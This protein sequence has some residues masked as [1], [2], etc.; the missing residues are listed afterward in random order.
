MT[1][2]SYRLRAT[3]R[4]IA[5]GLALEIEIDHRRRRLLDRAAGDVDHRP[6][7]VG[8]HAPGELHFARDLLGVDI[9]GVGGLVE[10]QQAVSANL[11]QPFRRRRQA[12]QTCETLTRV[13]EATS[14]GFVALDHDW[15]YIY[16]NEHA[17]RMFG[18]DPS[19][20]VGKH[21]WTEFPEAVDQPFRAAYER[22]AAEGKP[23]QIEAYELL[24]DTGGHRMREVEALD[25][26]K[27]AFSPDPSITIS[28]IDS[29]VETVEGAVRTMVIPLGMRR[30]TART[31]YQTWTT[32]E[33]TFV[34]DATRITM[35]EFAGI[36]AYN[37]DD[38]VIDRTGLTGLYQFKV[39]LDANQ[40]AIRGLRSDNRVPAL[41]QT[42]A[43]G[44]V[45]LL[46][47]ELK[48]GE[49]GRHAIELDA[50]HLRARNVLASGYASALR[51][52]G[53]GVEGSYLPN[54]AS[55]APGGLWGAA[56]GSLRLP[57]EETP[58]AGGLAP[59]DWALVT[60]FGAVPGD[61]LDDL[62]RLR[63][64]SPRMRVLAVA[65]EAAQEDAARSAGA[66][67]VLTEPF[68]IADIVDSIRRLAP[69]DTATVIDLVTGEVSTA[70]A[71]VEGPW[72]ATS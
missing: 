34:V 44:L 29:T 58:R 67:D 42:D 4:G 11:D 22:A 16:V 10:R 43:S 19:S 9:A 31:R 32:A 39:E 69:P 70:P 46:D 7:I 8:E 53:V 61:G 45:V 54:Y 63:V 14:D 27:T 35:S 65:T 37:I 72:F 36:L 6:A 3:R 41:V 57:V 66:D 51:L 25:E 47:S 38:P 2:R 17:G 26:L 13:L 55:G 62:N 23:R 1:A 5:R 49:P 68:S 21:I 64:E 15:R 12:E 28:N 48:G 30:V 71:P 50:G 56:Q 59:G 52:A 33:R 24:V 60:D 18:R 20:L 40:S